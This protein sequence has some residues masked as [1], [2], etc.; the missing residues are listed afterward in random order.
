MTPTSTSLWGQEFEIPDSLEQTKKI[1]KKIGS[2]TKTHLSA[3]EQLKSKNLTIEERLNIIKT[4]VFKILGKQKN[5][6]L[7]IK[8]KEALNDYIDKAIQSGEFALDTE[9]NNTLDYLTCKIMGA[10]FYVPNQKQAYIPI[11]HVN[12]KT[13]ER[14]SWQLTEQDIKESIQRLIDSKVKIIFHNYKFDYQVI[15]E[16]CGIEVPAYWDTM[17]AVKMIDEREPAGLKDQYIKHIDRTQKKYDIESL[18]DARYIQYAYVDP[19]LFALYAATDSM[20]TYKLYKYQLNVFSYDKLQGMYKVFQNIEMPIIKVVADM[21]ITGI[22]I[23]FDYIKRLS[24]K[25]HKLYDDSTAQVNEELKKLLPKIEAWKLTPEAKLQPKIYATAKSLKKKNVNKAFPFEDIN[26]KYKLG[27]SKAE[28]LDNPISLSSPKQLAILVYDILKLP[29]GI[30]YNNPRST[31]SDILKELS[32]SNDFKLGSLLDEQ[33]EYYTLISRYIDKMPEIV[34]K[35][36]KKIHTQFNPLGAETGRFSSENVNLQ[37]IPS[38]SKDIRPMFCSDVA[39]EQ[40]VVILDLSSVELDKYSSVTLLNNKTK[41]VKD[42]AVGDVVEFMND[43]KPE[44]YKVNNIKFNDSMPYSTLSFTPYNS[45]NIP[46]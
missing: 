13:G 36:D 29:E 7:V 5:N 30:D 11:N 39:S 40:N 2:P 3:A 42:L 17:V 9:T 44:Y 35:K 43:N 16:T 6:I 1:L 26:G 46:C 28:Q 12:Y 25:Y 10:C 27:K 32:K 22:A 23:D 21:E 18:F 41:E 19:E 34:S 38:H 37:N 24:N 31:E 45:Q 20:M 15:K 8:T 14:L 4:N 33:K